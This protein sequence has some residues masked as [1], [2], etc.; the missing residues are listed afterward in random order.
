MMSKNK[1]GEAYDQI[2]QRWEAPHFDFTNGIAAHEKAIAFS[3]NFDLAQ[4]HIST[5][6]QTSTQSTKNA[7]D[8]GCGCT[9][10]I[11]NL[12]ERH[13]FQVD[14]IDVSEQ[15]LIK[16]KQLPSNANY[17]HQDIQTWLPEKSYDFISAWDSVWHLPLQQQIPVMTKLYQ[18]L[19]TQGV[20]IFSFGGTK[21]ADEHQNNAM[22]PTIPY[23]TLGTRGFL[24]LFLSLGADC[25]HLEFDQ[26]PELHAYMIVK[27]P[28]G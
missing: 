6:K 5:Q 2:T 8:V 18:A 1:V 11:I 16:A 15:M 7:L 28:E 20:L 10:R 27:K 9:N 25:C 22:G 12:L 21:D 4:K 26:Y 24:E 3:K 19:T 23:S 13:Q 17:Y 14:A